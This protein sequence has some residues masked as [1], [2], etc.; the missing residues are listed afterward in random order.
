MFAFRTRAIAN[1]KRDKSENQSDQVILIGYESRENHHGR[2]ELNLR[3][4]SSCSVL[5]PLLCSFIFL[6]NQWWVIGSQLISRFSAVVNLK[7]LVGR[8]AR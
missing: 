6:Y 1:T 7:Y 5:V 3:S 2:G 8:D 4:L